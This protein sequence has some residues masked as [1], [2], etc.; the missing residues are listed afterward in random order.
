MT[1]KYA[2][3]CHKC[4][5]W[6]DAGLG[7]AERNGTRWVVCCAGCRSQA[8]APQAAPAAL[9]VVATAAAPPET[10]AGLDWTPAEAHQSEDRLRAALVKPVLTYKDG[11]FVFRSS[12]EQRQAAKAAGF[13]W[14]G[15]DCRPGC[16]ACAAHVGKVWW[17]RFVEKAARLAE[18]ADASAQAALAGHV[19]AVAASK[20]TDAPTL[21]APTLD[22]PVP[23]GLA[24]LPYQRAG[25]AY[26]MARPSTLIADEMGLGKTIMAIGCINADPLIKTALVIVPASLRLNWKREMQKWLTRE[27]K[28][29]VLDEASP[30]P[31]PEAQIVICN[32]E[33]VRKA[34]V[35]DVLMAREWDVLITDEAHRV[36]NPKAAQ[37]KAVLGKPARKDDPAVAGLVGKARRRLFLTGT[38]I[39]NKPVEIHPLLAAIAPVE[40]GNFMAFAK[41]YCAAHQERVR[42]HG[43][44]REVWNFDGASNLPELQ[45]RLRATCMV[46]RLKRDVLTELPAKRRQVVV[47]PTNGAA[48]AVKAE[49]D[50]WQQHELALADAQAAVECAEAAGDEQ[51]YQAAVKALHEAQRFA[52]SEISRARHDVA[53]AK[54]PAVIEHTVDA[55]ESTDKIVIFAHHHDAV[56]GIYEA[57]RESHGAVRLRGGLDDGEKQAAVDKFMTDPACRVFVGSIGA[58]GVGITLTAAS[59]VLFAELDWVPA[60]VSQAEDRCHR[61]GQTQ[62]VNVQHLVLDESLDAR[63]AHVIVEKQAIADAALD[64]STGVRAPDLQAPVVPGTPRRN[65][66]PSQYPVATVEQRAACAEAMQRLAG[67]CDGAQ[68][69]DG[70]G[71]SKFDAATGHR[72]AR[73]ARPYTDGECWLAARL[74]TKYRGQLDSAL[75]L[76]AGGKPEREKAPKASK[77]DAPKDASAARFAAICGDLFDGE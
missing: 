76:A 27:F 33:R 31:S 71:F 30:L 4:G 39:L 70:Q 69:L 77:S 49:Q 7:T 25:I 9:A 52:F 22:V 66:K 60:N 58:A 23:D 19:A 51:A 11:V 18:Y 64:L 36:K 26:T 47:L 54:I 38:P 67:V 5:T 73:L 29:E 44:Y 40:F 57:L 21:D 74:A 24:Y 8:S 63:M 10:F 6:V 62:S 50:A 12:Y 16:A 59:T 75:V 65:A 68:A 34:E 13:F 56:D 46:R 43:G 17:T 20:A 61:I 45:E 55:L 3:R 42:V 37:T 72:L 14:H 53:L 28:I 1:N 15:G 48:R 32:Y 2:G 35:M 41:R